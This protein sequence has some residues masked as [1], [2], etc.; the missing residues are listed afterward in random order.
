MD[1]RVRRRSSWA[2]VVARRVEGKDDQSP[3]V[4][5]GS[6]CVSMAYG[7]LAGA[8][9]SILSYGL[10]DR[11]KDSGD[12]A[13]P[14]LASGEERSSEQRRDCTLVAQSGVRLIGQL[15]E[16]A[17]LTSGS[18]GRLGRPVCYPK[19]SVESNAHDSEPSEVLSAVMALGRG[20]ERG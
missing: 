10:P 17:N 12:S 2:H 3:W 5:Y 19:L 18:V 11:A 15:H 4:R 6:R 8:E 20:R 1:G 13:P 14:F 16:N 9:T 7:S